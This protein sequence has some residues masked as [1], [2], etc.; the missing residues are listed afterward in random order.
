MSDDTYDDSNVPLDNAALAFDDWENYD[1]EDG[2][3]YD[4][5]LPPIVADLRPGETIEER[6]ARIRERNRQQREEDR[7]EGNK[8]DPGLHFVKGRREIHPHT[9]DFH[10]AT[11][12]H[13]A[14][15]G[16]VLQ[17]PKPPDPAGDPIAVRSFLIERA[18]ASDY[19]LDDLAK[20]T[21][22]GRL[23]TPEQ[24]RRNALACVVA[25]ARAEGAKVEVL[26]E[27]LSRSISTISTLDQR[28]RAL[29]GLAG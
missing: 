26:A 2:A 25:E 17:A 16:T 7:P 12:G 6:N 19:Q 21:P 11:P 18:K 9:I 13:A 3:Y 1:P 28:G 15:R 22:P 5:D 23:T 10:V 20:P 14:R 24:T 27:I 8:S 29:L 4:A